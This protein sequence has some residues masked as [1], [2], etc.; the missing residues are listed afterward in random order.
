[1]L[2]KLSLSAAV[3][4]LLATGALAQNTPPADPANP[5]AAAPATPANPPAAA[6][7]TP[8]KPDTATTGATS[9]TTTTTKTESV[10]FKSAMAQD[11]MLASKLTGTEVRNAAGENLGDINDLV[12]DK[13]GKASVAIIGVGGFLGLGEKAVGVPFDTLTFTD[14][15]DGTRVARL[16]ATKDSLK[17]APTFVYKDETKS[18]S[19][20][21]SGAGTK[22][23]GTGTKPMTE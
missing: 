2:K 14:D 1:M 8:A 18:T 7:A 22:P 6:P 10:N 20:T 21:A 16:D 11:E 17:A 23:M 19:T 9:T 15:K 5:P 12:M 13:T 4:A 3:A